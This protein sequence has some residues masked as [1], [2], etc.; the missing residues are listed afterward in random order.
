LPAEIILSNESLR[1][2]PPFTE[3]SIEDLRKITSIT[4]LKKFSKSQLLFSEGDLYTG[5]YILLKGAVKVFRLSSEGKES[6]FH[7]IKPLDSFGDIAL[8]EGGYY[9]VNAQAT[10]DSTLLF[11]PRKEFLSLLKK[12]PLLSLKML[13][14][15]AKRLRVLTL[16]VEELTTKDIIGRLASYLVDEIKKNGTGNLPEP[17][18]KLSVPKKNIAAFLGTITETLS[19]T[20]KKLQ[21]KQIIRVSGKNI[22]ITNPAKLKRLAS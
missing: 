2:L 14:S 5:F 20:F 16:K 1:K 19:R 7:L 21:D 17:F 22:F 10:S 12:K 11:I 4:K 3:L 13:E 18:V 8:F 9:V 15:F 6:I